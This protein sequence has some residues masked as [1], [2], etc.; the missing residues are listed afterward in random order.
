[1][2][3]YSFSHFLG[4]ILKPIIPVKV[5]NIFLMLI[6]DSGAEANWLSS[7]VYQQFPDLF[8][9]LPIRSRRICDDDEDDEDDDFPP[10]VE[11]TLEFG[12]EKRRTYFKLSNNDQA[13]MALQQKTGIQVHG[14]LGMDFLIT[15]RCIIDFDKMEFSL[16][17]TMDN[18]FDFHPELF[19][20]IDHQ[21]QNLYA[22]DEKVAEVDKYADEIEKALQEHEAE[23]NAKI[24]FV[25]AHADEIEKAIREHEAE[26]D[27]KINFIAA[28]ADEIE[29]ALEE[30]QKKQDEQ[31]AFIEAHADEIEKAIQDAEAAREAKIDDIM[32]HADEIEQALREYEES[33]ADDDSQEDKSDTQAD[34]KD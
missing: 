10:V 11:A 7:F 25:M 14:C 8:K 6:V 33:Q 19:E 27:A 3:T 22:V 24:E 29:R 18:M 20:K 9:E 17:E 2:I 32:A 23:E 16:C 34:K 28:H 26:E 31:I 15:N 13:V 12:S 1:M 5:G 4:K 21:V 30:Y